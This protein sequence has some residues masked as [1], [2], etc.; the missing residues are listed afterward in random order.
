MPTRCYRHLSTVD[1]DQGANVAFAYKI[2]EISGT[3]YAAFSIDQSTGVLSF[4]AQPDYETQ[5]SYN[6]II[7]ST[8]EGGK[9]FSKAFNIT[10]TN[11]NDAPSVANAIA[12]QSIAEDSALSIQFASNTFLDV[13]I[14]DSLTYTATLSNGN[15]LPSWLSF[16]AST[17]TFSGTPTNS[18]V[19]S[20][21]VKVTATDGSSAAVSDTFALTVTNVNDAPSVANAIADQSIAEDSALSIQ[22]ASNTFLDVDIGDSLTYTATLS[23][24]NS[25][26][27]W[28]SFDASTR[29]FSGTPTNSD[30]GSIDVKVTATDGSSAAVSDTFALTVTNVNDAPSVANAIADQSIAEDSAL[31]IQFASNTFLDVDIGDSLTY[32]ATLS[33]G[34]SLPSWLSFDAS[35]RTFSGTPTN[36]DVGSIDVKVTATDGSSA[37]V[38]DTFALT[39]T[40]VNDAPSVANAIADQSIAEDS[41]LSIQFASNTFLDVDIGDSLTYTATLSNGNSLPSWLSFDASTRTFSG[42]PTNSDVGS[43]DVKVTATDGSSA[44]VSDT[45]ALT[46][47]NVNDAPSVANAI[48][49]Q[50][51]AEDS[52]LS[53]QFASNTFLDVDIG[54]SL[55][56]T[57][58]LSNGNSL[59]S[60]LSFDASTRTFSGTPTNSDVGS[61]DV[62][63]TATDGSSAAV[64]DTF[65]LTVT[66]V[67]DAPSVANAIA[68]QS[69]A[70]DSALSIQFASNTFLDVDIGDSLTYTATLSNGN[71]LPSWLSFDASTRTFSGT[72]TN[73]DVGSIDVKVT[74]TDGSSSSVSDTYALTVTN[75]NDA[76]EFASE[77]ILSAVEDS[78]YT[79]FVSISDPDFGDRVFV[80][81]DKIP[82][83]L[84]YNSTLKKLSGTPSNAEVGEHD[85]QFSVTDSSGASPNP[86]AFTISVKNVNDSPILEIPL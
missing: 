35:T 13:D 1:A 82:T 34:N 47:T 2:A 68:D 11:V 79:Y 57:A 5:S 53:I 40:N 56:Y 58:T 67:N 69:I 45:F 84:N 51:I 7:V 22:F 72:P 6:I 32:T 9:K 50:S 31:S 64:S 78:E 33:N 17:R 80:T 52:A 15:S 62:K 71:S 41:A 42:T 25:L 8:D 26:P 27:S 85:V 70:E 76:P 39:V 38:S 16:D 59:P 28:L 36:S 83:W 75:V 4:K 73:S 10:V 29:T 46:V 61:I 74:A 44:A 66:N 49:D 23:N 21:D 55:T 20:I 81:A 18:D 30:V 65:A 24:G 3:D 12:D 48:A 43:I 86:Q 14:G 19:G 60:W 37:A 54:D 63:V 77:P